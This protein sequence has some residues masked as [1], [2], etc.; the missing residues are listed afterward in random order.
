MFSEALRGFVPFSFSHWIAWVTLAVA[1]AL[2]F[3]FRR[4]VTPRLDRFIRIGL[5]ALMLGLEWTFYGW[6][7]STGRLD[8]SLLPFGLCAMSLYL[9]CAVLITGHRRLFRIVFPWAIAGALISLLVADMDYRFPHFRFIHY[10]TNH[11]L[12]LWANLYILFV[13]DIRITYRDVLAS[14]IVLSALALLMVGINAMLG[15]NHL[16]LNELP[17]D[18]APAY[19]LFGTFWPL[20][21]AVSIFILFNVIY[22]PLGIRNRKMA[23]LQQIEDAVRF[24]AA[25]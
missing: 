19:A 10:F 21:F 7:A 14:S 17:E 15:T 22:V 13:W 1:L 9:T 24:E 5:V 16:F 23:R 18:V 3:R 25:H 12:F 8:A 6:M 2:L 11:S 20:A 4:R